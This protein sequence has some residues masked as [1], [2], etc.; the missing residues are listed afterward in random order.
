MKFKG[1]NKSYWLPPLYI[2]KRA[3]YGEWQDKPYLAVWN[4][5]DMKHHHSLWQCIK[6]TR[7]TVRKNGC[8][9]FV[10]KKGLSRNFKGD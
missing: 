6:D 1:K 10:I 4:C 7:I 9:L 5:G 2:P 8:V 3:Q